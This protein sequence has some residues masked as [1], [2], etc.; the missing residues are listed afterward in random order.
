VS[1]GGAIKELRPSA[2]HRA[3]VRRAERDAANLIA[4]ARR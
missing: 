3:E 4:G 1:L 2:D